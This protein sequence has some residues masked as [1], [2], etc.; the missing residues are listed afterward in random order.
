MRI[1]LS[2][3]GSYGDVY[4]MVG[5]GTAMRAR[6]HRVLVI[7]NPHFRSVIESAQLELV[8]IGTAAEYDQLVHHPDLWHPVRGPKL[9]LQLGMATLL[10]ELYYLIEQH[11]VVGETVLGAHALDIAG[12]IYQEKHGGPLASIHFAPVCLRSVVESPQ[13]FGMLL[14]RQVPRWLKR[15]QFWIGDRWFIDRWL[16]PEVGALRSELGLPP[17]KRILHRWFYSPQR[18]IGLFP[19]WF[20]PPQPDWPTQTVLTGFPL[21]DHGT[22]AGP[23]NCHRLTGLPEEVCQFLEAGSAPI[24]FS[25]GSAMTEGESF[26]STAVEACHRLGRRGLLL[27][28]YPDQLPCKLPEDVGWFGFIPFSRLLPHAAALVHH[29]GIGSCAQGLASG[30]PQLVMPM[31]YDQLDNGARLQRLGVGS[32]ISRRQFRGPVVAD[33]LQHL[34]TSDAVSKRCGHW[35]EQ[36]DGPAALAATCAYL[37][38][39]GKE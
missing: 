17:I 25:P 30:R 24:V 16:L 11:F 15:A 19:H 6:G 29:G 1:L 20:A 26:F 4:P 9:A 28:Q 23:M 31:A 39:L 32:Y 27:T 3:L 38:E 18:I 14:G 12:R 34:L 33:R 10:R 21:W 7:A 2:A 36:C 22:A 5:L 37:E 35:A 13:M 8:P